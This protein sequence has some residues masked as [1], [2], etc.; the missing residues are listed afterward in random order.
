VSNKESKVH[1][2]DEEEGVRIAI[3]RIKPGTPHKGEPS[4]RRESIV[5]KSYKATSYLSYSDHL[6]FLNQPPQP[7]TRP[8]AAHRTQIEN[9]PTQTDDSLPKKV[10]RY[11]TIYHCLAHTIHKQNIVLAQV[12]SPSDASKKQQQQPGKRSNNT[13]RSTARERR[14]YILFVSFSFLDSAIPP[15]PNPLDPRIT[16][17][18][19]CMN[20]SVIYNISSKRQNEH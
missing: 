2:T 16:C 4:I 12:I 19:D 7:N 3:S 18:H 6:R 9:P 1:L 17:A 10:L 14:K 13:T 5:S 20:I 8:E 11:Q 15:S